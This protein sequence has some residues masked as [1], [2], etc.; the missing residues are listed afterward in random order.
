M[1]SRYGQGLADLQEE[2]DVASL[3]VTGQLPSWLSGTLLRNGPAVWDSGSRT[4][5]HWFDGMAML[6]RFEVAD[7]VV[8][9]RNRLLDTEASRAFLGNGRISYGEFATDPCAGLFGRFFTRFTRRPTPNACVN[10]SFAGDRALALTET[11]LPVEFDAAT[12]ETV[13]VVPYDDDLEAMVTTAHPHA[14][15]STGDAVN[16]NLA[17]GRASAYHFYRQ[18]PGIGNGLVRELLATVPS[19][20]PG[21]VHSFAVTERYA[22]LVVF[23]LAVRPLSF[24]LRNRPFIENY[25]WCPEIGTRIVVVDLED[26][27]VRT[28]TSAP[29]CFAFHHV[30]AYD[31]LD[32]QGQPTVVVDLCS[33]PDADVVQSLYLDRLRASSPAP[34]ARATRLTVALD[35]GS[36]DVRQLSDEPFELPRIAYATHNGRPYR[37]AYGT[38]AADGTGTDF[39]DQLVKLDTADGTS[40]LW[41]E[42]GSYPGEPVFV[43]SP[44]GDAEDA[45]VVLSLVL[46]TAAGSSYLLVLDAESFVELAR[47]GVPHAVPFGFH[48]QFRA[49]RA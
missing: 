9:Y 42:P 31:E 34:M 5:R 43:A 11:P 8:S 19:S 17:F 39:L 1:T 6:H 18:R 4:L 25:R 26:G 16:V 12:L 32:A 40:T 48:G 13:G 33:Y 35:S 30:N 44:D 24:V 38:G 28:D 36:V 29:A 10:V 41:H 37:Y 47:A 45:G 7:G 3:P 23:P 14:V 20:R 27:T 22:V 21:Y 15:P 46:D 2:V 49:A